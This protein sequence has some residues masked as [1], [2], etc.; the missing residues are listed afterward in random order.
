MLFRLFVLILEQDE[1]DDLCQQAKQPWVIFY[2]K[3]K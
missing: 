2:L 3:Q 1:G